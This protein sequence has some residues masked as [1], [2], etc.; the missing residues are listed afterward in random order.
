MS[1]FLGK[2][3]VPSLLPLQCPK[4][5]F[6]PQTESI[7]KRVCHGSTHT[8]VVWIYQEPEKYLSLLK[9][10]TFD[11]PLR[12]SLLLSSHP[13]P[14]PTCALLRAQQPCQT[15][16]GCHLIPAGT[17]ELTNS[18]SIISLPLSLPHLVDLFIALVI[19]KLRQSA[20]F[21]FHLHPSC[22]SR[23]VSLLLHHYSQKLLC[24]YCWSLCSVF[25]HF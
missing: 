2:V 10:C 20:F 21:S 22:P 7:N 12:A 3:S 8:P 11:P 19:D 24:S 5:P 6:H 4:M 23:A 14:A 17:A 25:L 9:S 18:Q 15:C 13:S 1:V 16:H